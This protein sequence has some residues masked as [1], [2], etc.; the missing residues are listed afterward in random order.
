M[1]D[2][3][4]DNERLY[5]DCMAEG[6]PAQAAAFAQ[7]WPALYRIAYAMLARQPDGEALASDCAQAALIKIHRSLA[8]CHSPA[9]FRAWCAQI[10]RRVVIDELRRPELA[11]RAALPADDADAPAAPAIELGEA[12]ELRA[13]LLAAIGAA[14]LSERSRRVVL[15]RFFSEQSDESLAQAESG[16][17]AQAVLPSHIQVTRA[18]NLAK[19]RA[20][21]TLI[22]RLRDFV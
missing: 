20:N 11:R 10:V 14:P 3:A 15:G 8:S 17:A 18:K 4:D 22:E 2:P 19:L 6:S 9:R 5:A 16:L 13:L 21:T 12:A 1:R 7:L